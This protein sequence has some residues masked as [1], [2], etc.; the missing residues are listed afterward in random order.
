MSVG[1]VAVDVDHSSSES[2]GSVF[3]LAIGNFKENRYFRP[4][5]TS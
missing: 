4:E 2:C 5:I 1:V 3:P